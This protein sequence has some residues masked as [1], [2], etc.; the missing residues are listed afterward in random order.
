MS[1][2]QLHCLML[3]KAFRDYPGLADMLR[4]L[5]VG[6]ISLKEVNANQASIKQALKH[7]QG[8][9][10]VFV[11]QALLDKRLGNNS[12]PR[13]SLQLIADL[14]WQYASDAI[15]VVVDDK[16]GGSNKTARPASCI[17]YV[18]NVQISYL[19]LARHAD[20]KRIRSDAADIANEEV[21]LRLQF[22]QHMALLKN[23]FR[24]CKRLLGISE[25]RCQWLVDTSIVPI[26][27]ISRDLHLY[28]NAAYIDLFQL[29]SVQALR[30]IAVKELIVKEEH[31]VFDSFVRSHLRQQEHGSTNKQSLILHMKNKN[32]IVIR[33]NIRLTPCVFQGKRCIQLWV[34]ALDEKDEKQNEIAKLWNAKGSPAF[35]PVSH[36]EPQK[37]DTGNV[38]GSR[39]KQP[40]KTGSG[41]GVKEVNPAMILK[42]I[43]R[44]K[45]AQIFT[46]KLLALN[47]VAMN[48]ARP[49][50]QADNHN[51][52]PDYFIISLQVPFVQRKA[53]DAL[54]SKVSQE[55]IDAL[56]SLFWDK[57]KMTRLLQILSKKS[58]QNVKLLVRLSESSIR[59]TKQILWLQKALKKVGL[60]SSMIIFML[61]SRLDESGQKAC[62]SFIEKLKP[63]GCQFLLDDFF[64]NPDSLTLLKHAKPQALRFSLPWVQ[65]IE[66]NEKREIALSRLIRQLEARGI[67]TIMPCGF[68]LAMK[69]LF[70]LS[71]ASFCQEKTSRGA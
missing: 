45:E 6:H 48:P 71:G 21:F 24:V 69:K 47:P 29:K 14:I 12:S 17:R 13:I 70:L 36:K 11:P 23:N 42:E 31:G 34:H 62:V 67:K 39:H 46:Q 65:H 50:N 35:T 3:G 61:P 49:V 60:K 66:G 2:S 33:T 5:D 41:R 28:A 9:S 53:V 22:L 44:R 43:L 63:Y 32:G 57:V 8:A 64:V 56:R 27:F 25:K 20:G 16:P 1:K 10:L 4:Q 30:T 51:N 26:A 54:L 37:T 7:L 19:Q 18:N 55:D 68:S 59:Y 58:R 40:E 15:I 52:E 38:Q